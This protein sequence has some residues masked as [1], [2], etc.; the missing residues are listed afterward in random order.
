MSSEEKF[1]ANC[2]FNIVIVG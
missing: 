2:L 1:Q